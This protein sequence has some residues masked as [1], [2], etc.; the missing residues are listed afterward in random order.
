MHWTITARK[1][2]L[3]ALCTEGGGVTLDAAWHMPVSYQLTP[4][5]EFEMD[6]IEQLFDYPASVSFVTAPHSAA[7]QKILAEAWQFEEIESKFDWDFNGTLSVL[8]GRLSFC[9]FVETEQLDVLT[10]NLKLMATSRCGAYCQIRFNGRL[11]LGDLGVS[12]QKDAKARWLRG[13]ATVG[14]VGSPSVSVMFGDDLPVRPYWSE[15]LAQHRE[16]I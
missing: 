1:F 2:G 9:W 14:L 7:C 5:P 12:V 15:V 8:D 11:I 16:Q 13:D 3:D 4:T 10:N 6:E